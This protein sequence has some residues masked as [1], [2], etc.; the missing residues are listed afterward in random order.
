M[1]EGLA[2]GGLGL[3]ITGHMYVLKGRQCHP[4]Q[5][6][7]WGDHHLDGLRR[8]AEVSQRNDTRVVAQINYVGRKPHEM[9][10]A[11]IKE[12]RDAFVAASQRAV[13]AGFDGV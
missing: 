13:A 11:E 1:Y 3:I 12:A 7:I 9:T 2:A 4:C 10:I 6:G 5:T 8:M